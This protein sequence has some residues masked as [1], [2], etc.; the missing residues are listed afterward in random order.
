L[1][2]NAWILKCKLQDQEVGQIKLGSVITGKDFPTGQ[3]CKVNAIADSLLWPPYGIGQAIIFLPCDFYLLLSFFL[4]FLAL[5]QR[6]EI[7]WSEIGCLPYFHTW[8]G[9][10]A[11]LGCTSETWCTRLAENTGRK[12]SPKSRHLCTIIHFVGLYLCN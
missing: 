11:N 4:F 12:K 10:S 3:I 2:K 7:G 9:L 8:C 6:S 5:S 1:G